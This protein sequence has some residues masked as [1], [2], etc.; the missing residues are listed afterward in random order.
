[1]IPHPLLAR[2]VYTVTCLI[3]ELNQTEGNEDVECKKVGGG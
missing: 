3:I 1:M 2:N